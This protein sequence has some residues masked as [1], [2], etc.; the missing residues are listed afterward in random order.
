[1]YVEGWSFYKS[2]FVFAGQLILCF[3]LRHLLEFRVLPN[4]RYRRYKEYVSHMIWCCTHGFF[5]IDNE[6]NFRLYFN[7]AWLV[8]D[9][10]YVVEHRKYYDHYYDQQQMW[11]L[12][13]I[14]DSFVVSTLVFTETGRNYV[15]AINII[16]AIALIPMALLISLI[17]AA[18]S[19]NQKI[20]YGEKFV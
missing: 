7:V 16:C 5:W 18:R 12:R 4:R 20:E 1:M 13:A 3:A 11:I 2:G 14:W 6:S 8:C 19:K 15:T 17:A 9:I 10:A